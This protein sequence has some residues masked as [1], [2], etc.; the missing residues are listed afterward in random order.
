MKIHEIDLLK[1]KTTTTAVAAAA[2]FTC[3]TVLGF[4]LRNITM[5]VAAAP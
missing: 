4:W 3:D 1:T 2:K 5:Q